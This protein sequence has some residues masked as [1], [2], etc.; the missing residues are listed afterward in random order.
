MDDSITLIAPLFRY[1]GEAAWY[2]ASVEGPVVDFLRA[3]APKGGFGSIKVEACV[4]GVTWKTSLFPDTKQS[5]YLLPVKVA[6]RKAANLHDGQH[7][8]L[9]FRVLR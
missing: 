8:E 1:P 2:F 5:R 4:A 7:I 3:T 9:N 6:V